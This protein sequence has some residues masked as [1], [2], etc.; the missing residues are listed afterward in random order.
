MRALVGFYVVQY[1]PDIR[2]KIKMIWGIANKK[3]FYTFFNI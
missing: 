2:C 3:A 1:L